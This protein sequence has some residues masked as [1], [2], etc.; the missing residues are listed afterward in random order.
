MDEQLGYT[1][2]LRGDVNG[3]GIVDV[4]DVIALIDYVLQGDSI[5]TVD[6]YAYDC[7]QDDAIDIS[8]VI[9]LIDIVLYG[10]QP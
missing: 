8:D 10:I 3:D 9:V 1:S 5:T 6:P 7:N 2:A 4:S